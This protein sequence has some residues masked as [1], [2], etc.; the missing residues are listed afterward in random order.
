MLSRFP[1]V[2]VQQHLL[3][4]MATVDDDDVLLS[5]TT[6]SNH[7]TNDTFIQAGVIKS[8]N[9]FNKQVV[10]DIQLVFYRNK[11][12]IPNTLVKPIITWYHVNLNHPGS[13]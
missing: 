1:I 5:F 6:I 13:T 9:L 8:P 10:H 7:Q 4:S 2:P 12:V 3:I 11:I